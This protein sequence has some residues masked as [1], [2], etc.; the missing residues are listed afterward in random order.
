M[1][2]YFLIFDKFLGVNVFFCNLLIIKEYWFV[3][4]N[5]K[6]KIILLINVGCNIYE[7]FFV[8][9]K[10]DWFIGIYFY[11]VLVIFLFIEIIRLL[12]CWNKYIFL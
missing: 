3:L 11:V 4:F 9:I 6:V 1:I 2:K 8:L 10:I 12:L 7:V 5:C